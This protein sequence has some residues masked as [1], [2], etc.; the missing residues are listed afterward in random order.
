MTGLGRTPYSAYRSRSGDPGAAA[1]ARPGEGEREARSGFARPPD[2]TPS[3]ATGIDPAPRATT[4]G[5]SADRRLEPGGDHRESEVA[6]AQ[7]CAE[8]TPRYRGGK[9]SRTLRVDEPGDL[10]A[11]I[12]AMIGFPPE[13][14]LVVALLRPEQA[15]GE[16]AI[17]EAVVR[18]DLDQDGGRVR[19]AALIPYLTQICAT[20]GSAEVLVVIVD[21]RVREPGSRR[22]RAR[23]RSGAG[24]FG[25]LAGSLSRRLEAV[26]IQVGG[27]WMVR[28]LEPGQHWWSLLGPD[29]R[30]VLPDPATSPVTL[31]HVLDGR[32]IRTGRS[33]LIALVTPDPALTAEV[34]ELLDSA[35]A[36]AR[37]RYARFVRRGDPAGY[38][39]QALDYV[40]W[41]ITNIESGAVLEAT[42]IAELIAALR[43]RPVRDTMFALALGDHAS[44]AEQ[45]WIA[46]V[47]ASS[48]LDRAEFATLLAFGAYAR[49][50][51]PLAGIAL[52][53]ALEAEPAHPLAALLETSLHVGLRPEN[54]R[55]LARCGFETARDLGIDLGPDHP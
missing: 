21:D 55:R 52:Q 26:G 24:P 40:L 10:L 44:A 2:A 25:G 17:I 32:Q 22:E 1:P 39:R 46:L 53:V 42:E 19:G 49:G 9:R 18:F 38:S 33:E 28:S 11:A 27:G 16:R 23:I 43:D 47:R 45:L 15:A 34:A 30:G 8:R 36:V 29:H 6:G 41:Q 48:G 50:D 4:A 37:D 7:V 3:G 31:A 54:L 51:G 20:L 13:R 12:P 5:E 35:L 14:S